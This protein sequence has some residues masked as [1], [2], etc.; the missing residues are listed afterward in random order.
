[1]PTYDE[2]Y[3]T[4]SNELH[5]HL[6]LCFHLDTS[7]IKKPLPN[8]R[9]SRTTQ[10]WN[11]QHYSSHFPTQFHF[12]LHH[13]HPVHQADI[14]SLTQLGCMCCKPL[15][16]Y[17]QKYPVM[18]YRRGNEKRRLC[19]LW[20]KVFSWYFTSHHLPWS[21]NT[22]QR[23]RPSLATL[24]LSKLLSFVLL[25]NWTGN[26]HNQMC[27]RCHL[28]AALQRRPCQQLFQALTNLTS[29]Y[30]PIKEE[31]ISLRVLRRQMW[32]QKWRSLLTNDV[33]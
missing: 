5:L 2:D 12:F 3:L 17:L 27:F 4:F 26:L 18:E 10:V 1:M 20:L 9:V 11:R 23:Q 6:H 30:R 29:V 15:T 24:V 28:S 22:P 32:L 7:L 8:N 25:S 14:K 13:L 21:I 19:N 16:W 31:D 33:L